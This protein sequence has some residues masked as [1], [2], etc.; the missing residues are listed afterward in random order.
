MVT[1]ELDGE[2]L[3][4]S[5]AG[6]GGYDAFVKALRKTL[7]KRGITFPKLAD[8]EVVSAGRKNDALWKPRSHGRLPDAV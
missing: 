8:Y 4:E 5:A 7:K 2:T 3:S 6:D 1:I